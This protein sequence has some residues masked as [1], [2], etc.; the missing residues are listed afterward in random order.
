MSKECTD[1]FERILAEVEPLMKLA[2]AECSS[3]DEEHPLSQVNLKHGGVVVRDYI[4]HN[5]AGV[6][7]EHLLYMIEEP[8]LTISKAC[9]VDVQLLAKKLGYE[10]TICA[11]INC[12]SV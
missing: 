7:F 10:S 1:I 9:M 4:D 5:E 2:Y 12:G 3:I 11:H 6:A 8:P